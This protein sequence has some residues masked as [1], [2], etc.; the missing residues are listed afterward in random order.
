[1]TTLHSD[2]PKAINKGTTD[3]EINNVISS[4]LSDH[5]ISKT[6]DQWRVENYAQLRNW[7]YPLIEEYNDAQIKINSGDSQL[8]TEGQTQLDNYIQSCLDVKSR[9]PKEQLKHE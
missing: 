5:N 1:M 7:A 2:I 4:Y 6:V 3:T 8:E 9:F